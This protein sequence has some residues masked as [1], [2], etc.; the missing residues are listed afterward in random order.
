MGWP[1]GCRR[2][3]KEIQG[4]K[5]RRDLAARSKLAR[6][7]SKGDKHKM[8]CF[9]RAQRA[10]KRRTD[11]HGT[12]A[13]LMRQA[14]K[15]VHENMLPTATTAYQDVYW[16]PGLGRSIYGHEMCDAMGIG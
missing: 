12:D 3:W 13:L 15:V 11:K 7:V 1:E 5:R 2:V 9:G 14:Q 6:L 16:L 8:V 10:V 4:G